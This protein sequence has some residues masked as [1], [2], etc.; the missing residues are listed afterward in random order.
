MRKG[1]ISLVSV[2]A[3]LVLGLCV[4]LWLPM[5]AAAFL[6]TRPFD[7]G[8]YW[9]GFLFRRIGVVMAVLNPI[10]RFRCSGVPLANP[11]RPYV[12]V[13]NHESFVDILLISNLPWEMKWLSK[14][15]L[16]KI[17]F[18]GWEM[19]LAGD[20]PLKRGFGPSAFE[21]IQRCRETL[22]RRV[23]VMIFPEGTRS[24][25][26]EMLP[27]KEGAFRLAI[28]AGVPVLP[29]VVSGTRGALPANDWRFG[30]SRAEVR[31]LEPIETA[32]LSVEQSGEL[33]ER[34]R[35]LIA[36][37]REGMRKDT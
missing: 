21:A 27:F 25:T 37:V 31:V 20:I 4:V 23:S 2:W 32:G 29:L 10:W 7:A 24:R 9:V 30:P 3:W 14:V 16:F 28:E 35:D 6:L 22:A 1:W 26:G 18:L 8:R 34:V 13:S 36:A 19:R 33:K 12:V 15:E 5:M 11:R 17:P